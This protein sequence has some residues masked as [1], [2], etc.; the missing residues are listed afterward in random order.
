VGPIALQSRKL[1]D[2]LRVA[3]EVSS[4]GGMKFETFRSAEGRFSI[5]MP[6]GPEKITQIVKSEV[7]DIDFTMFV[8]DSEKFGFV[9]GYSDYPQDF[10]ETAEPM[11][12]LSWIIDGVVAEVKG[13]LVMEKVLADTGIAAKEFQVNIPGKGTLNSMLILDG[14]R[15]YQVIAM[16]PVDGHDDKKMAE[17]FGS[18]KVNNG[19]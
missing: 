14:R 15:L 12:N 16:F 10:M 11:E 17:F 8:A 7:G 18:F 9:V 2:E 19:P 1:A 3:R 6:G 13:E 4:G 5:S